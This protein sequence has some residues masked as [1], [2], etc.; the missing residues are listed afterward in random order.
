MILKP[1]QSVGGTLL[2]NESSVGVSLGLDGSN[3]S[4]KN[5]PFS[6]AYFAAALVLV[7]LKS[8]EMGSHDASTTT[9]CD[10]LP[11]QG[12]R[13]SGQR[14]EY[15]ARR[16]FQR[17]VLE[18][19]GENWTVR[20][21][22]DML[23]PDGLVRRVE[24][25]RVVG[26]RAELTRPLARRRADEIV[27]HVNGFNYRPVRVATLAEFVD[28][29][30]ERALALMKPSTRK[31]AEAHLRVYL[32]PQ[33]GKARLDEL[34]TGSVQ[35]FVTA[36]AKQGR[37]RHYIK[38]VL[39]T[40]RSM[41]RSAR[42]WSYLVGDFQFAD[43]RLPAESVRKAPRFFTASQAVEIIEVAREPWRTVFSVA[44]MTGMRPGEVFGLTLDDLDFE[45]RLIH[46]RQTAYYS[47]LQTPKTRS[48]IASVPMPGP[49][50][51][52]LREFLRTWKPNAARLLFATRNGTPFAENNV[53]QRRLWPILD[54]LGIA[55]CG[56]H[57]FRHTH[58]SLLVA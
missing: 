29:W 36:M 9:N 14:R 26:T 7:F 37:S 12:K 4:R 8:L 19:R 55:R 1:P 13:V 35:V 45:R 15:L 30:K 47:K 42:S 43:L 57:A 11:V 33:F 58:A 32:L 23:Q 24:V 50:E 53:V 49:L 22:E 44:A 3:A 5:C 52:V 17:G 38:N 48:S 46:V 16:R 54:R 18:L 40:L 10:S 34:D 41:L 28:V 31:A 6:L 25:R 27:S 20:F 51:A 39:S 56:M 2:K 21:R